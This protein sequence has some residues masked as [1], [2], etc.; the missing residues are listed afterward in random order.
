MVAGSEAFNCEAVG[1]NPDNLCSKLHSIKR[2]LEMTFT[3][4]D[5][6]PLCQVFGEKFAYCISLIL[7]LYSSLE[8]NKVQFSFSLLIQTGLRA[9]HFAARNG[10]VELAEELISQGASINSCTLVRTRNKA[11]FLSSATVDV[12]HYAHDP[13][14]VNQVLRF[15]FPNWFLSHQSKCI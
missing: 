2:P 10:N 8:W 5:V 6:Q 14:L 4:L 13:D 3:D 1:T 12:S 7:F 9:L 15:F 11:L